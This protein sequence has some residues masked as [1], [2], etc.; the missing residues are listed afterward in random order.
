MPILRVPTLHGASLSSDFVLV[1][2]AV[3]VTVTFLASRSFIF[4]WDA[5]KDP[6]ERELATIVQH[7]GEYVCEL[8]FLCQ[9]RYIRQVAGLV[10]DRLRCVALPESFP[11]GEFARKSGLQTTYGEGAQRLGGEF[12]REPQDGTY[13][14]VGELGIFAE[15]PGLQ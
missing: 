15:V 3:T 2:N 9:I 6:V 8:E 5:A 12:L 14:D 10:D 1:D 13:G 7:D 4:G 11:V